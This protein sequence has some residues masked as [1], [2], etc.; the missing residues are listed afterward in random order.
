MDAAKSRSRTVQ[1][2]HH[3]VSA[4]P[5]NTGPKGQNGQD[6]NSKLLSVLEQLLSS[7]HTD[8]RSV[9]DQVCNL[10][11]V[12]V[13]ADKVDVFLFS[14]KIDTLITAGAS[15]T[16]LARQEHN[17]GLDRFPLSNGGR[18]V[19]VFKTGNPY[20]TG[21]AGQDSGVLLGVRTGLHVESILMAR[22]SAHGDPRGVLQALSRTEDRFTPDD[23]VFIEAVSHWIGLLIHQVEL[24]EKLNRDALKE[25]RR[26]TADDVVTVLAHDLGNYLTPLKARIDLILRRAQRAG[27]KDNLRDATDA[28][29]AIERL[30]SLIEDLL[31]AARVGQDIF[32]MSMQP[33]DL[34]ELVQQTADVIG[35]QDG[36]IL[37]ELPEELVLQA[38]PSR[39]RQ[40]L[41]NLLSNAIRHSPELVPVHIQLR[42]EIQE[43]AEWAVITVRDEGP[44]IEPA[45]LPRL[46]TRFGSGHDS[47]GLGLGLY[48]AKGI[49]TAHAGELTVVT[50]VGKGTTFRLALPMVAG[51]PSK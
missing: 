13:H 32:T 4:N 3:A 24:S 30:R 28:K 29:D 44:G 6:G 16:A 2:R 27:Q 22:F 33:V 1:S 14:P 15:D 31:D 17:L 26:A 21:H 39:I 50:A 34:A 35:T 45:L 48:L 37:L 23:L 40:A 5:S 47:K 12:A 38:D 8:I 11:T 20:S 7:Q 51:P 25:A 41:E 10:V 49:V 19:E 9:L 46:F 18:T 42:T 43:G 36:D